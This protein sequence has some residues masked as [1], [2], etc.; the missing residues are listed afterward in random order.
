MLALLQTR[1]A[2]K[3]QDYEKARQHSSY[4]KI[5]NGVSIAIGIFLWIIVLIAQLAWIVPLAIVLSILSR[6]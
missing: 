1:N 2:V 5:F 6:N 4:T 3:N